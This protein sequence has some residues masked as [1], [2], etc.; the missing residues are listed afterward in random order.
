MSVRGQEQL[1]RVRMVLRWGLWVLGLAVL[2]VACTGG[3]KAGSGGP[4]SDVAVAPDLP[5]ALYQGEE[6][7]GGSQLQLSSLQGK[8]VVL[9]FWAGLCPPCRAEMPDIEEFHQEY[10]DR[11]TTV[12]VDV[13]EF[14][15]LG[16]QEDARQLL[17][18]LGV[19]YPAGYTAHRGVIADYNVLSMPTTVFI[20]PDG[21]IFRRWSGILDREALTR[22]TDEMLEESAQ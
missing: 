17:T 12:G 14:M 7:L 20:T 2:L 19:T 8:A 16:S 18:D 11:V 1:R 21:G 13:G 10:Q 4:A 3:E 5:I 22:V 15:G 9:N 6:A